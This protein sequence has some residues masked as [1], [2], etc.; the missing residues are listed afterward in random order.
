MSGMR[1]LHS[2]RE[3][4]L[5]LDQAAP[6]LRRVL[7]TWEA[8]K[9]TH[10]GL[11][12]QID[13]TEIPPAVLPYVMLVDLERDTERLVVRLA[14]TEVC[15]KHGGE[16]KGKSTHDFFVAE[17][18]KIVFASALR[19]ADSRQPSL[20]QRNY[21]NIE[22][23]PWRYTRLILPLSRNG[24]EVDSFFKTLDPDTLNW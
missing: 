23:K 7:D 19:V 22:G 21:V 11:P 8:K 5:P 4:E 9:A 15:A 2:A 6:K 16:L 20:A 17:D 14:G 18:A 10:G 24:V 13:I 3:T 1:R 12:C